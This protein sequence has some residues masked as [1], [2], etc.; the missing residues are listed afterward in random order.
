MA[1][2]VMGMTMT[3]V[4]MTS[5]S[6]NDDNP[7]N[8]ETEFDEETLRLAEGIP[9][10][11]TD[12]LLLFQNHIVE[13]DSLG[14]FVR[15]IYGMALDPANSNILSIGVENLVE[16]RAIF[17]DWLPNE[18]VMTENAPNVLTFYP[19]DE[20][21]NP[22]GEIYFTPSSSD[23]LI[24]QVTFSEGT[25]L[26][27]FTTIRFI[28]NAL[29]PEIPGDANSPY[30]LWETYSVDPIGNLKD[31]SSVSA[32]YKGFQCIRESG[33][34]KKGLLACAVNKSNPLKHYSQYN[35]LTKPSLYDNGATESAS[36]AVASILCNNWNEWVYKK[37]GNM[38]WTD[39]TATGGLY[40]GSYAINLVTG[41][42]IYY[43]GILTALYYAVFPNKNKF[44][45]L[46]I[47][48]F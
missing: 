36:K 47:K 12:E 44:A 13:I 31:K 14:N 38:V 41:E 34:G 26:R 21:G 45:Q 16:A 46:Y 30:K 33:N 6:T 28:P 29:W 22:Q 42:F 23:D 32:D 25:N 24:A 35:A 7:V 4:M 2:L 3:C 8:G 20:E 19:K 39:E 27:H 11:G 1:A 48:E 10:T 40:G 9:Q 37:Q 15:S 43:E 17:E 5:C 18:P